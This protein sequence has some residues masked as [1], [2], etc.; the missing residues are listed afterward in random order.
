MSNNLDAILAG[1]QQRYAKASE[2]NAEKYKANPNKQSTQGMSNEE[3]LDYYANQAEEK[4]G[5]KSYDEQV[6]AAQQGLQQQA[7]IEARQSKQELDNF[8]R[9]L[10]DVE[11]LPEQEMIQESSWGD[12]ANDTLVGLVKGRNNLEQALLTAGDVLVT[13][14]PVAMAQRVL[15]GGSPISTNFSDG[16]VTQAA[17]KIGIDPKKE[18][19][20]LDR[21]Y[22]TP[23]KQQAAALQQA[24][25]NADGIVGK[26]IAGFNQG[27]DSPSL[28][29]ATI[30]ESAPEIFLGSAASAGLKA[31]G[32]STKAASAL[33]QGAGFYAG[34]SARTAMDS[35]DGSISHR[36]NL[37]NIGSSAATAGVA[38][39]MNNPV[40]PEGMFNGINRAQA[41]TAKQGITGIATAPIVAG[42]AFVKEGFSEFG[43]ESVQN[44]GQQ[45]RETG[46]VD[47]GN[48]VGQA[49]FGAFVGNAMATPSASALLL[50]NTLQGT[51]VT[52]QAVMNKKAENKGNP[53]H[54]NYDPNFAYNKA[55][56]DLNAGKIDAQT[57]SEAQTTAL[58]TSLNKLD[59]Y[60][61]QLASMPDGKDKDKLKKQRDNW[62]NKQVKPLQETIYNPSMTNSMG[63]SEDMDGD[64]IVNTIIDYAGIF[65]RKGQDALQKQAEGFAEATK[66]VE[67][68]QY[69]HTGTGTG[70]VGDNIATSTTGVVA[71]MGDY[72]KG[73]TGRGTND[74]YDLRTAKDSI[75]GREDPTKYLNR[76]HVGGKA[77]NSFK[78]NSKYKSAD[79][80]GL[81]FGI[82]SAFGA[83]TQYR[84]MTIAPE[85]ANKVASVTAQ[86]DNKGGGWYTRVKFT[87]GVV[88]HILHQNQD[89]AKAAAS[90]WKGSTVQSTSTGTST[91]SARSQYTGLS[92]DQSNY[93]NM[94]AA[95]LDKHN[96]STEFKKGLLGQIGREGSFE[97]KNLV[98]GHADPKNS[99]TNIGIISFQKTRRTNLLN[100]LRDRGLYDGKSIKGSQQ[101][102]IQANVDF[103]IKEINED[104]KYR[105]TKQLQQSNDKEAIWIGLSDNYIKW[106]RTDP[107]YA[108]KGKKWFDHFYGAAEEY[109]AGAGTGGGSYT[110][111]STQDSTESTLQRLLSEMD[112]EDF[113]AKTEEEQAAMRAEIDSLKAQIAEQGQNP[114]QGQEQNPEQQEQPTEEH[115]QTATVEAQISKEVQDETFKQVLRFSQVLDDTHL[116]RLVNAG[117]I[118]EEHL[119]Q[120][121]ELSAAKQVLTEARDIGSVR[122]TVFEGNKEKTREESDRGLDTYMLALETALGSGRDGLAKKLFP[123]L[124]SWYQ[125]HGTKAL[126]AAKA[127][128][129]TQETGEAVHIARKKDSPK[130]DVYAGHIEDEAVRKRTGAV[131]ITDT[132]DS[133]RLVNSIQSE[134]KAIAQVHRAYTTSLGLPDVSS[135]IDLSGLQAFSEPVQPSLDNMYGGM[136]PTRGA[137]VPTNAQRSAP[138][139]V[140]MINLLATDAKRENRSSPDPRDFEPITP[141]VTSNVASTPSVPVNTGTTATT[142]T[143]S[144]IHGQYNSVDAFNT[145]RNQGQISPD[146]VWVG[147]G[148]VGGQTVSLSKFL[149]SGNSKDAANKENAKTNV[150]NLTEEIKINGKSVERIKA[151]VLGN[152]VN[153]KH[154]NEATKSREL[155]KEDRYLVVHDGTK[156]GMLSAKVE[157]ANRYMDMLQVSV[158]NN[159]NMA[160]L[161]VDMAMDSGIELYSEPVNISQDFTESKLLEQV[162]PAIRNELEKSGKDH[163]K[164][165][166]GWLQGAVSEALGNMGTM[167]ADGLFHSEI[168]REVP[169]GV[170]DYFEKTKYPIVVHSNETLQQVQPTPL[171][172]TQ[173]QN[174]DQNQSMNLEQNQNQILNQ[175]QNSILDQNQQGSLT[176]ASQG[177]SVSIDEV[178]QVSEIPQ[179]NAEVLTEGSTPISDTNTPSSVSSSV[180]S[181][182]NQQNN[183]PTEVLT[184]T[185]EITQ[186]NTEEA[187]TP[188]TR[189]S[190]VSAKAKNN[191]KSATF[192]GL[193]KEAL[194]KAKDPKQVVET[195]QEVDTAPT[196]YIKNT[197]IPKTRINQVMSVQDLVSD[198]GTYKPETEQPTK[199]PAE[200]Q[201]KREETRGVIEAI[202]QYNPQLKIQIQDKES[203]AD[204]ST[205]TDSNIIYVDESNPELLQ[206]TAK[207]VVTKS[208]AHI[209]D[210]IDQITTEDMV[211]FNETKN[212]LASG[213]LVYEA[214][215]KDAHEHE[216]KRKIM[217]LRQDLSEISKTVRTSIGQFLREHPEVREK[218][219]NV[220]AKLMAATASY[221]NLINMG[222]FDKDTKAILK[223]VKMDRK[224]KQ[225]NVFKILVDSI[226]RFFGGEA[227]QNTAYSR[228]IDAITDASVINAGDY[229]ASFK[230]TNTA[231]IRA[232]RDTDKDT[233]TT[234]IKKLLFPVKGS[235]AGVRHALQAH[236]K[237]D[238]T[239]KRPLS[240]IPDF[241][242]NLSQ[243]VNAAT[244]ALGFDKKPTEAQEKQVMDFVVFNQLFTSYLEQAIKVKYNKNYL[245]QSKAN[246]FIEEDENGNVTI[247]PNVA[248]ALSYA[249]YDYMMAKGNHQRNTDKEIFGL[250]GIYEEELQDALY[251]PK[252]IREAYQYR[253][254]PA[255][256][257]A[258]SLGKRAAQT[259]S[260]KRSIFGSDKMESDLHSALGNWIITAMQGADLIHIQEM[261]MS[262]HEAN[263]AKLNINPDIK[264]DLLKESQETTKANSAFSVARFISFT[265]EKGE[266]RNDLLDEITELNKG[267]GS[268]LADI[269]GG[270]SMAR[271]PLLKAPKP[272]NVKTKIKRTVSKVSKVQA[273]RVSKAQQESMVIEE[274]FFAL[275]TSLEAEH[276]DV[277]HQIIGSQ[278]TEEQLEAAHVRD[279]VGMLGKAESVRRDWENAV[280]WI[281]SIPAVNGVREFWDTMFMATNT[282]MHLNATVMNIQGSKLHRAM[283]DLKNF[284]ISIKIKQRGESTLESMVAKIKAKGRDIKAEDL[285]NEELKLMFYIRAMGENAEGSKGFIEKWIKD[286]E[287]D[288]MFK[289]GFTVDKLP[290]YIFIPAFLEYMGQDYIQDAM[291]AVIKKM[292]GEKL[293]AAEMEKIFIAVADMDMEASSLRALM[294]M[295]KFHNATESKDDTVSLTTSLGLGSDGLNNGAALAHIW[296]GAFDEQLLDRTGFYV[297][298]SKYRSY[299]DARHDFSVGDYY[300]GFVGNV[301]AALDPDNSVGY[302]QKIEARISRLQQQ[303]IE[304]ED[305]A[306]EDE[307]EQLQITLKNI[308]SIKGI[309]TSL[310]KRDVA[311]AMLVPLNYGASIK[312]LGR[313]VFN[314]FMDDIQGIM[315]KAANKDREVYQRYLGG[316]FTK[317]EY[318]VIRES[319]IYDKGKEGNDPSIAELMDIIQELTGQES[320]SLIVENDPTNDGKKYEVKFDTSI[321]PRV[322]LHAWFDK[323]TEAQ[324]QK[325]Y[326]NSAGAAVINALSEYESDYIEAKNVNTD[327]LEANIALF[328]EVY[329]QVEEKA[330]KK[331]IERDKTYW[332]DQ[333]FSDTE[334]ENTAK[335][336]MKIVGLTDKDR[337]ELVHSIMDK[338]Q[339][340]VHTLYSIESN[341]PNAMI[342]LTEVDSILKGD[343][344]GISENEFWVMNEDGAL[345]AFSGNTGIRIR[346]LVGKALR[347]N[348]S[349]TQSLDS[350]ISSYTMVLGKRINI[351]IHDANI[352]ALDNQ[353][354]MINLQ[355]KAAFIAL[356]SYSGQLESLK[357]LKQTTEAMLELHEAKEI[358][359]DLSQSGATMDALSALYR[360][361][362]AV[363]KN[364]HTKLDML[365]KLET[366]SQYAGELGEYTVTDKDKELVTKSREQVNE[367]LG[368]VGE[369]ISEQVLSL[370]EKYNI[371]FIKPVEFVSN[372]RDIEP[373]YVL[374][375][376]EKETAL[377][378]NMMVK[379]DLK[380]DLAVPDDMY[381]ESNKIASIDAHQ[382]L[383]HNDKD[384]P[385]KGNRAKYVN[386]VKKVTYLAINAADAVYV[387]DALYKTD[388]GRTFTDF[389]AK[390]VISYANKMNKPV[391]LYDQYENTWLA[392]DR[393]EKE[394]VPAKVGLTSKPAI[395][396]GSKMNTNAITALMGKVD[397]NTKNPL[398]NQGLQP[399]TITNLVEL[400]SYISGLTN[401]HAFSKSLNNYLMD[402]VKEFNPRVKIDVSEVTGGYAKY[403]LNN[404]TITL[405][406]R[407]FDQTAADGA[408]LKLIN[409]ELLHALTEV[410]IQSGNPKYA[411]GIDH[412]YQMMDQVLQ[413][414]HRDTSDEQLSTILTIIN[415]LPRE[416]A[417][418]EFVAYGMTEPAMAK[419]IDNTLKPENIKGLTLSKRVTK[420]FDYFIAAVYSALGL[421]K[422]GYKAFA[423]TVHDLMDSFTAYDLFEESDGEGS[424]GGYPSTP[425]HTA[426]TITRDSMGA[427]DKTNESQS[428][429][430]HNPTTRFSQVFDEIHKQSASE[431]YRKVK[432]DGLSTEWTNHLDLMVTTIYDRHYESLTADMKTVLDESFD[433]LFSS[434]P[435]SMTDKESA[436][437]AAVFA[438][439]KHIYT[440]GTNKHIISELNKI[441]EQVINQFP[442][443]EEYSSDYADAKAINDTQYM[444]YMENQFNEIF[445]DKSSDAIPKVLALIL[446]NQQFSNKTKAKLQLREMKYD[447][448]FDKLMN[449]W[450]RLMNFT[451]KKFV[452]ADNTSEATQ[453]LVTKLIQIDAAVRLQEVNKADKIWNMTYGKAMDLANKASDAVWKSG[454]KRIF[455]AT[456]R[457]VDTQKNPRVAKVVEAAKGVHQYLGEMDNH[458]LVP[459]DELTA[460]AKKHDI[461]FKDQNVT[462]ADLAKYGLNTAVEGQLALQGGD[463][464]KTYGGNQKLKSLTRGVLKE[465]ANEM[466]GARGVGLV[467]QKVGMLAN[468]ISQQRADRKK[469]TLKMFERMMKNPESFT[470]EVKSTITR[471]LLMS[472]ASA[473]LKQHSMNDAMALITSHGKRQAR[474]NY[475]EKQLAK[476]VKDPEELNHMLIQVKKLGFYMVRETTVEDMVKSSEMIAT[477]TSTRWS[478]P[479]K[480]MNKQVYEIVDEMVTLYA[481]DTVDAKYSREMPKLVE[482]ERQLIEG[483]LNTHKALVE[484]S[485]EDFKDNPLNYNKGYVPALHD[486]NVDVQAITL[487]QW[488]EYRA[489]GYK[490]YGEYPINQDEL[491][492]TEPRILVYNP[493]HHVSR[494]V[495]GALE[496]K[497]T[498][499][500][501]FEALHWKKNGRQLTEVGLKRMARIHHRAKTLNAKD[502]NPK[503]Y[504]GSNLIMVV[505]A[506]N[507][508][509]HYQYEMTGKLRDEL[510]VRNLAFDDV[511]ATMDANLYAKPELKETQRDLAK[512]LIED[513]KNAVT[514]YK[515][516]PLHFTKIEPE[517]EDPRVQEMLRMM[518][519]EYR[520][521]MELAF[522]KGKPMYVRTSVFNSV[523]GFRKYN[524]AE[525]FDKDAD[526][527]NVLEKLLT[528]FSRRLFKNEAVNNAAMAQ[529]IIETIVTDM[530]DYIVIRSGV[531]LLGNIRANLL[532]LLADGLAPREIISHTVYAWKEGKAYRTMQAELIQAQM[533]LRAN[534]NDKAK[535][536][537]LTAKIHGLQRSMEAN[538]MHEYMQRGLMSTIV[539]DI[540]MGSETVMFR[541][542]EQRAWDSV[543]EKVPQ[544]AR[545]ALKYLTMHPDTSMYKFM[546]EATQFSDFAAK[547]A[548]AKHTEAKARKAGKSKAEAFEMGIQAAQEVFINY[549]T[550]TSR[551]MQTANDLG[552]FMFTKFLFRFQRVLAR[553]LHSN[554]GH[555]IAQHLLVESFLPYGGILNPLGIVP[556]TGMSALGWFGGFG[557]LPWMTLL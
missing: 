285:T 321:N 29:L 259:L 163:T 172:S 443:V 137:P 463:V 450:H 69:T 500:K 82:N 52:L 437:Y 258:N 160:K 534:P 159:S 131:N 279:H 539:E 266:G 441:H 12:L 257:L 439:L 468:F 164:A 205:K 122:K 407:S 196:E 464:G 281:T 532:V 171:D 451:R 138:V 317:E 370:A 458:E 95:A 261:S 85:W 524:I 433:T 254:V 509:T 349:Q 118:S 145:A 354:D 345:Q 295:A 185:S 241:V 348:A 263:I 490:M 548:L 362:S 179:N 416:Q 24:I 228:L 23:Y 449:L 429:A 119:A 242:M 520:H 192:T 444:A 314:R 483:I 1:I 232:F 420:A 286:N 360:H 440:E 268:F 310:E 294:E 216:R 516:Q 206:E 465:L 304:R 423:E 148:K 2:S 504:A 91:G 549:D 135:Q 375:G 404:N 165:A 200:I 51:G 54:K 523:F 522:G 87:D 124:D 288:W 231:K 397:E 400:Q 40:T 64:T 81:D 476:L 139:D 225:T 214:D 151:G 96:L 302:P 495:T 374:G 399:P 189:K 329:K 186:G 220:D 390:T 436:A 190:T 78:P 461:K 403:D 307:I 521:E 158:A 358:E 41:T 76:F 83:N 332:K 477:S 146:A 247:E 487:D 169:N 194:Q 448:W 105:K 395:F 481:L 327:L 211:S 292:D 59:E 517:S 88:M 543:A 132:P 540:D 531:V 529:R 427:S 426:P 393:V 306:K 326:D 392:Y 396:E 474:Y 489:K 61:T 14:S 106:R 512:V 336:E 248:S 507:L 442:S 21:S 377:F 526:D 340:K 545:T 68:P 166:N 533:E 39:I 177:N 222:I 405:D 518:P 213:E 43:E 318:N 183:I 346:E 473:L 505:G 470:N 496:M 414:W 184:Q 50:E 157:S 488:D 154:V 376:N 219:H 84:T 446:T 201:V 438:V 298:S 35:T 162:L 301:G 175:N 316:E 32:M 17:R 8:N 74:H 350:Y 361:S 99:L 149:P 330:I 333:G 352:G 290:S 178:T 538:G 388:D 212:K 267:T 140:D 485:K 126:A 123:D 494:Y 13:N 537:Q 365:M 22:S 359:L 46:K 75:N 343:T 256:V 226:S 499:H 60:D 514:G 16:V 320:V 153:I 92:K 280:S 128:Q 445:R 150:N 275:V 386:N 173:N 459:Q 115:N 170:K 221:S 129:I 245:Y 462:Y 121:R 108:T 125:S 471:A 418:S 289:T 249:A 202:A 506:D 411:K 357:S 299:F 305:P 497:D 541:N 167:M 47:L 265:N 31:M 37:I 366:V 156:E 422:S 492:N 480:D 102:L 36:D 100:H 435:I 389:K 262:E 457:V 120:L 174:I 182:T 80:E 381:L 94:V 45:Y 557:M 486:T 551:E 291:E 19:E 6:A 312:G 70:T 195:E 237:Q 455:K 187:V 98:S 33:G 385:H 4:F 136:N 255:L 328:T 484:Q 208:V 525:A 238:S 315:V 243:G 511:L 503:D 9:S 391:Y 234:E 141:N 353:I 28:V 215:S 475:L 229:T 71:I 431:V 456:D 454:S 380:Y 44:I 235:N 218:Y 547:Y 282:R 351:N 373:I 144:L 227:K 77:L 66:P 417:L 168:P 493:N 72:S 27:F 112:N 542:K 93:L 369:A 502:Y 554:G 34:E 384:Y 409:H 424:V 363:W 230:K 188:I 341:D 176:P 544:P 319:I 236:F 110:S 117:V 283:A 550:P 530:K 297:T 57:A 198:M 300:T 447:T 335:K 272:D 7:T 18:N 181:S 199:I 293:T 469:Q 191:T 415:N 277:F 364:E 482:T 296:N 284:K 204:E 63:L 89:G 378:K 452:D 252:E 430:D 372:P 303:L 62:F 5:L 113:R 379:A 342:Q 253:G 339:A 203:Y 467:V 425:T 251:L 56:H 38:R 207:Q 356:A 546:A 287:Y 86:K 479:Y 508:I 412:L 383:K 116:E 239:L 250:L 130:W 79:H 111:T 398:S 147:R 347:A 264:N 25:N 428:D 513:A 180:S 127:M 453:K 460:F 73:D 501:G 271:Y 109:Y 478:I 26:A 498:H 410:S 65:Y 233:P 134:A 387:S 20:E 553:Q 491:D 269:M 368:K 274:D 519:Y 161:L 53:E 15:K 466:I 527:K 240:S 325:A 419:F 276:S 406:P 394:F 217:E 515:K 402:A 382:W 210:E 270:V 308:Q 42:G 535:V 193:N 10:H 3:I 11:P 244:E 556:N 371:K 30:S 143:T 133:I 309:H 101:E 260:I 408:K 103:M 334:A 338:L 367:V 58:E 555:V 48:A 273:E 337:E 152:P 324:L 311:K 278:V 401:A 49:G 246:Y 97:F 331:V 155:P 432:A 355:N 323:K 142:T 197:P 413:E 114:E 223:L 510:L 344:D 536:K 434:N 67:I 209:A 107:E 313:S 55:A 528:D 90:A 322:L 421:G 104:P 224:N 472:D 552:L